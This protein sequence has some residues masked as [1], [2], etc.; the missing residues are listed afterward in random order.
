MPSFLPL[1]ITL[2]ERG[3]GR[4]HTSVPHSAGCAQQAHVHKHTDGS[5]QPQSR[6][7]QT[8]SG[9]TQTQTSRDQ[10]K[11]LFIFSILIVIM[12]PKAMS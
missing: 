11:P 9:M 2:A 1:R 6:I 4:M 5:L 3:S 12:G 8:E 7:F 10:S